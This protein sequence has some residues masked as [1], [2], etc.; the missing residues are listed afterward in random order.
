MRRHPSLLGRLILIVLLFGAAFVVLR[1]GWIPARLSPLPV[2]DLARPNW[3]LVDWQLAELRTARDLCRRAL[4]AP[5]IE[6]APIADSPLK[7]G[8][9]WINSVRVSAA[10]GAKA[11]IDRLSCPAAAALALW[12]EHEVQPVAE[13]LLG[14][15]VAAL[16]SLGSYACRNI[17]G[18]RFWK[19]MRSE[20]ATANALDIA[21]FT[22]ADGHQIS[23]LKNW[24]AN[25]AEAEFLRTVHRRACLYFRVV[26]GPEF[27][28]SHKDH[29][30]FDRG[31][32]WSCR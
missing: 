6:A 11:S 32:L 27:N 2:I 19:N 3:L 9:G 28:A 17:V 16:H 31:W 18:N 30:H 13:A 22:L 4:K 26:L 15:R 7:D 25:G 23:V 5:H 1:Q 14:Q 12:M 10:G 21:G 29:F 24:P 8:C 20:H